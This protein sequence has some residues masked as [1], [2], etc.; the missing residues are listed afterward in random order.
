[1]TCSRTNPFSPHRSSSLIVGFGFNLTELWKINGSAGIDLRTHQ[2][3]APQIT[4]YRDLHCWEMN[5]SWVPTGYY[6]NYRLEIRLKAP[7][8][9]D[10][11]VTKQ[12]SARGVY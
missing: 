10:I 2:I 4:V 9:Q 7:Q 8:L 3:S 1:M 5:F 12:G 11:K 6:R